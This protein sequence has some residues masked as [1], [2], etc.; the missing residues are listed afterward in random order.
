MNLQLQ[1]TRFLGIS[2]RVLRLEVYVYNVYI[3]N[4]FHTNSARGGG[5]GNLL[6]EV[7]VNSKKEKTLKTFVPIT[8]KNSASRKNQ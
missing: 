8:Y 2:L 7:T 5:G 1:L 3:T 4:Q 6:V